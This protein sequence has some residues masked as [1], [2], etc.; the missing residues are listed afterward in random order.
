[1]L[2]C[3]KTQKLDFHVYLWR[4]QTPSKILISFFFFFYRS[5]Y[6][7]SDWHINWCTTFAGLL[8]RERLRKG[9]AP[10]L[11]G[12]VF[13]LRCCK[14]KKKNKPATN[15][16]KIIPVA[17]RAP[18]SPWRLKIKKIKPKQMSLRSILG[19]KTTGNG[20]VCFY[21]IFFLGMVSCNGHLQSD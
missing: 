12:S 19:T 1:M 11:F 15:Y 17:V 20:N 8:Y 10:H 3:K 6:C 9:W 21:F 5:S 16:E 13:V 2:L 4:N 18:H 14:K 7:T